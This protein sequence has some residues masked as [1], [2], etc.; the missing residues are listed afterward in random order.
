MKKSKSPFRP[1]SRAVALEPRLLFDGAG[2]VAVVDALVTD[3]TAPAAQ[4][5]PVAEASAARPAE[6]DAGVLAL[7]DSTDGLS[8]TPDAQGGV[9]LVVDARVADY[10]GLLAELPANVQVRVIA[11]DES[12]LAVV[13]EELARGG[14]FDAIHIISH[15]TPGNLTLGS[16]QFS[17]D[18]LASQGAALQGWAEYLGEDADILL[19]GCDVA[20]GE[21]GQAFIDQLAELTGADIAASTDPTGAA[22]QG[23]DWHLE[24]TTGR[25]EAGVLSAAAYDGLLAA[26]TVTDGMPP[27]EP[28]SIGENTPGPVGAH[29]EISGTGSDSLSVTASV[30]KGSLN[31]TTFTGTAAAVESWLAALQYT[32]TGTSQTGDSDTLSLVITNDTSGGQTN[33]SRVITIAPRTTHRC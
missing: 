24:A 1:M 9:L 20:Q 23:G 30:G 32:Y 8:V 7:M 28:A 21:Q 22:G 17:S 29:I 5:A 3:Y 31:A 19:Y 16:D 4:Q 25:I 13:S 26:P 14:R 33:F 18:T 10:Q 15:G 6:G 11:D 12:G 27:D 2:A